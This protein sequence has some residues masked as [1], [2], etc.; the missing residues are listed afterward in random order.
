MEQGE[1][2]A[3]RS[4]LRD[5]VHRQGRKLT[6]SE[7]TERA[8]GKSLEIEPACGICIENTESFI[9][10]DVKAQQRSPAFGVWA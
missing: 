8:T 5:N 4:W 6:A 2:S 1:F 10:C 9:G 3:L 7:V